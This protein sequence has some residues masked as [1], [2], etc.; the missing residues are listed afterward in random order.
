MDKNTSKDPVKAT[1][2]DKIQN[3]AAKIAGALGLGLLGYGAIV[4][5]IGVAVFLA[6][7]SLVIAFTH[8][9]FT[10]PRFELFRHHFSELV[11]NH[12]Q[13]ALYNVF[14]LPT[15]NALIGSWNAFCDRTKAIELYPIVGPSSEA[16]LMEKVLSLLKNILLYSVNFAIFVRNKADISEKWHCDPYEPCVAKSI[17]ARNKAERVK[18]G[19]PANENGSFLKMGYQFLKGT[20]EYG[21]DSVMSVVNIFSRPNQPDADNS[22]TQTPSSYNQPS[23]PS[24]ALVEE[25]DLSNA[26]HEPLIPSRDIFCF[27]DSDPKKTG[28]PI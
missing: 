8:A 12:I 17:S 3:A 15:M 14:I 10:N 6:K 4:L 16:P 5:L 28:K 7:V 1:I 23:A 24:K 26:T 9:I 21:K 25:G 19:L 20:F 22:L 18:L 2:L 27:R 11:G 13:A